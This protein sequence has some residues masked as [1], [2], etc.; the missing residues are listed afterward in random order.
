L[1]SACGTE[2]GTKRVCASYS[3]NTI[4]TPTWSFSG[5]GSILIPVAG[6]FHHHLQLRLQLG[7]VIEVDQ[8]AVQAEVA[9]HRVF[10]ESFAFLRKSQHPGS[11]VS[12][13]AQSVSRRG[14][15]HFG[16]LVSQSHDHAFGGRPGIHKF[17]ARV[18][19]NAVH[20][21]IG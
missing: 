3:V 18:A 11:E 2:V 19:Q 13:A 5:P 12:F 10:F 9:D 17:F 21:L 14:N 4:P 7:T 6:I 16:L 8:G 1:A 15:H 20:S